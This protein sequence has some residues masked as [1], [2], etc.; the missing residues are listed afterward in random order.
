[1]ENLSTPPS[2]RVPRSSIITVAMVALVVLAFGVGGGF[3]WGR[4]YQRAN[5]DAVAHSSSI[6]NRVAGEA[7]ATTTA[8]QDIEQLF[9]VYWEA[10]DLIGRDF[11]HTEPID[12]QEMVYGSIRGMLQ[13]LDDDFTTFSEPES[14][15]RSREDLRGEFEGIGAYVEYQDGQILIVSPIEETPAERAGL[16][17]G[18]VIVAVDGQLLSEITDGLERDD[19]LS[20]AIK[21]IRGPKGSQV[22]LT[23][24][25]TESDE[26]FD[27][28]IVRD[29]IPLISVRTAMIG[30]VAYINLSEFKQTT[31][32]EFDQKVRKLVAEQQPR[33]I[34]LDLRNNPGGYVNQAQNIVGRFVEDGV[35]YRT[36]HSSGDLEAHDVLRDG[37]ALTFFDIPVVVL[38]NAGSASAS[39]IVAG[40]LQD[41]DRATLLGEKTFGK[42]SVQ[43]VNRLSD[44]SELRV[45]IARW[46]TPDERMIHELGIDPDFVVPFSADGTEYP[47]ECILNQE[48]VEDADTCGDSQLYWALQLLE[49]QQPPPP[50]TPTATPEGK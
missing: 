48:P 39:E 25:R 44:G 14:A 41:Y 47:V 27:V 40:A 5:P 17:P 38:V 22:T 46:L 9:K 20:A 16:R 42:G 18:D 21:L 26:Q 28:D 50:P 37:N 15:E 49:G 6:D 29:A 13:S 34:I 8:P 7:L 24:F 32:D 3:V 36:Q 2:R 43:T 1:M 33:A 10:W 19:A 31:F 4:A 45:T 23:I 30:D 11:Y 12:Q 35:S